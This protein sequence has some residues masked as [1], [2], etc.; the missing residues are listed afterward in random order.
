[1]VSPYS[2]NMIPS[3]ILLP[4]FIGM[5]FARYRTQMGGLFSGISTEGCLG[6]RIHD[7]DDGQL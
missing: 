4:R 3:R 7:R 5:N 2:S 6:G 1:M